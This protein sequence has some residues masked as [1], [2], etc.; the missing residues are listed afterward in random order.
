VTSISNVIAIA[1]GDNYHYPGGGHA[2]ALTS[3]KRV[4]TWGDN[5]LRQLGRNVNSG[6]FD[7]SPAPV[8]SNAVAIAG[9]VGFTLAVTSNGQV[10]AWG[11]NTFGELGTSSSAVAFTNRPMLVA[12]ISNAVLVSAPRVGDGVCG[13]NIG[14]FCVD[15]VDG[16]GH[17]HGYEG[18]AHVVAMTVDQGTNH[19]WGWGD[20]ADGEVG[21]GTGN[22]N[23]VSGDN[24][25]YAPVLVQ[26]CTRC[27]RCVQLGTSGILTAQCNGTLYLYFNTD[28]FGASD[29][30]TSYTVT[31]TGLVTNVSVP[32]DASTGVAAGTVTNGGVYAY[33]A[34]GLCRWRN[35]CDTCVTDPDGNPTNGPHV[36]CS[37]LSVINVTNAVCPAAA[38]FSL[39]GKIQ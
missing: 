34:N 9:G 33:S 5:T 6:T 2:I 37:D 31:V 3:D 32:A 13:D 35:G 21:N 1:A 23:N 25:V 27:Q 28:N 29:P 12:G 7:P 22:V 19:Y 24:N 8:M 39:V 16:Q 17:S 26:F 18:G 38:C 14:D 20:N 36:V 30:A 4:W 15:Y 10:Y 11:D